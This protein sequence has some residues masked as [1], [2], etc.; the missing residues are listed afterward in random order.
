[1]K[2]NEDNTNKWK[3]I[4][5]SWI[6]RIHILKVS[7]LFKVIYR[8][9][10]IPIKSPMAFFTDIGKT[11]LKFIQS[12]KKPQFARAILSKM[13][14]DGGI[15]LPD[16][17]LY[18]KTTVITTACTGIKTNIDKCNK[19]QSPEISPQI[20]GQL[21]FDKGKRTHNGERISLQ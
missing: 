10:A 16:F 6:E 13:N 17:K 21:I 4:S 8:F 18:Q 7:I 5:C 2:E 15:T 1:M 3:D 12:H 14:N 20:Y 11:I 19:L 9:N